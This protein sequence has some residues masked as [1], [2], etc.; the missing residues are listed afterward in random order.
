MSDDDFNSGLA[1]YIGGGEIQPSVTDYS[2]V[3]APEY[4]PE[5]TDREIDTARPTGNSFQQSWFGETI[6][7]TPQQVQQFVAQIGDTYASDMQRLNHPPQITEAAL[8]FFEDHFAAPLPTNVVRQ[9][10]YEL[11]G[12]KG[13]QLA[14]AFGNAMHRIGATQAFITSTLWFL[15]E[16]N[17]RIQA[18]A[19]PSVSHATEGPINNM[20]VDD[21][22]NSLSD[23][24]YDAVISRN[25]Q[26]AINTERYLRNKWGDAYL[27]NR[28]IAQNYLNSLPP[29]HRAHFDRMTTGEIAA[30]NTVEVVEGLFNSAIGAHSIGNP[31][32]MASERRAIESLMRTD[33]K[34]YYRDEQLQ[35]RYR[36]ILRRQGG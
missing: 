4:H 27:A 12:H 33:P 3:P 8:D 10:Q 16:L 28:Q 7:A 2:P 30:L 31:A 1:P 17:R 25:Q 35:A 9:H 22:L 36:E 18:Q 34:S 11:Y 14:E 5:L 23:A 6:D 15:E 32:D 13:D 29:S 21:Y 24:H 20:T 26:A 19:K